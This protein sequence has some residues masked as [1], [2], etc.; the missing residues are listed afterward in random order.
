M[1]MGYGKEDFIEDMF[2]KGILV[3]KELL[4]QNLSED[5][6]QRIKVEQDIIVLNSDYASVLHQQ[7]SLVDWYEMD[8]HRVNAE[9]ERDDELYQTELQRSRVSHINIISA[10][11]EQALEL[12]SLEAELTDGKTVSPGEF[13]V[14]SNNSDGGDDDEGDSENNGKI[15]LLT[16][17]IINDLL[18]NE[19]SSPYVVE[20]VFTFENK[21]HPYTTKDFT[22]IFLSR[23]RFLEKILLGRQQL[24]NAMAIDRILRK[25]EKENV[26]AIGM[27]LD[28][29]TTKNGNLII[30]LEDLTGTISVLFSKNKIDLHAL[31]GE[32]VHDEIVCVR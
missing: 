19:I 18:V 22:S 7:T 1:H 14:D 6:I 13:M 29:G 3:N 2:E 28:T 17:P 25:T 4:E 10:Q 27:V 32:L 12:R 23:Y 15:K 24:Q 8:K 20:I 16:S 9:K 30:K 5:I 11:Q 31:A 21:P 26:S